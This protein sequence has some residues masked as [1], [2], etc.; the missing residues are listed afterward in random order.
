MQ[1]AELFVAQI[2]G[3]LQQRP[4]GVLGPAGVVAGTNFVEPRATH[5]FGWRHATLLVPRPAASLIDRLVG[6]G[7]E[8]E[9]VHALTNVGRL[10]GGR[11]L[12]GA[13]HIEADGFEFRH[14]LG[15]QLV[16]ERH[17]RFGVLALVGPDDPTLAVVIGHDG[18]I[19]MSL[20]IGD[21][22]DPEAGQSL[23]ATVVEHVTHHVD[24]DLG[25]GLPAH[26]QQLGDGGLVDTLGEPR[27]HR[28]E[29][30]R[31]TSAGSRPGHVLGAHSSAP[32][33]LDSTDLGF[34]KALG[35]PEI[36]VT[37]APSR[38]VVVRPGGPSAGT[39]VKALSSADPHRDAFGR[40][41]HARNDDAVH[42]DDAIK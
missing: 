42:G 10:H 7:D 24:N 3:V 19:A 27:D 13:A 9:G 32:R 20:P 31:V 22:V 26:A 2:R 4:A 5:A 11:V 33:A 18:Q 25:N 38:A 15:P 29:G 37:P 23:E 30:L 35:Q 28:T 41:R 40:E 34:E 16:E 8:M 36:E 21:L 12:E 17:E 39:L 1:H 14:P 6:E